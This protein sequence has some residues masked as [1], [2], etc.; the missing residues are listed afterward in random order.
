MGVAGSHVWAK[1]IPTRG[2]GLVPW[3]L[4][5]ACAIVELATKLPGKSVLVPTVGVHHII[6]YE[7]GFDLECPDPDIE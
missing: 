4:N 2:H 3:R 7:G 5:Y 1:V 6:L